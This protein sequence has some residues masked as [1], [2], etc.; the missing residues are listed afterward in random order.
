MAQTAFNY[1]AISTSGAAQAGELVAESRAVALE[2]LRREGLIPIEVRPSVPS[3]GLNSSGSSALWPMRPGGLSSRQLLS[4]CQ[5]L[6]ALLRAGLTIDRALQIAL[7]LASTPANRSFIRSLLDSVRSGCALSEALAASGQ[8]LPGYFISMIEAGEV[9]GSLP[10]TMLR[11][12]TLLEQQLTL[13]E[14][15]TSALIYPLLLT[16]MLIV[17]LVFLLAFVLPRFESLF[18]ESQATLPWSTRAVL[19]GGRWL[20]DS[21]LW[22]LV[23]LL[24]ASIGVA[25]WLRT[26]N[27]R[28]HWHRWLLRSR[29]TLSLPQLINTSRLLRTLSAL[30]ANGTTL[31]EA[32]KV[33]RGT[34]SN[35]HLRDALTRAAANVSA[36]VPLSQAL[37]REAVFP[38]VAVQLCQVGEE[39]GR[40]APL[41]DS[42]ADA[43]ETE[44]QLKLERLLAVAVPMITVLMGAV[45]AA[46]IGS[47]LVG[48][49]SVNELA[50]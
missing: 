11:L 8:K 18:A 16:A 36:G 12:S 20:A 34:L 3:T 23:V 29:I 39:T 38:E 41:M 28:A 44:G 43:L 30:S 1:R 37:S 10:E 25:H 24:A 33:A 22:V 9:G 13:R 17:T 27:G 14:R 35:M 7:R 31:P 42:A 5:S 50:F 48:L 6:S 26:P 40:L 2:A 45:V 32:I 19:A 21:W 15:L 46:L 49:L 47:V 4:L